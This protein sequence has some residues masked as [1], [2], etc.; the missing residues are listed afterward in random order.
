MN[1]ATFNN[2]E[3]YLYL[4]PSENPSTALISPVLDSTNYHSWSR[5]MITALSAKNKIEFVDGSAPEPLKTDRTYGAWRRCN[6]MVVSWIVHSVA[7]SIRQSILWMDKSED[8]WRDLKSRY[9]QGDLLRIF[10]LQQEASTLRQGA[11]SVTEYFTWLRVIWDEIENFRPDPVCTCNIRCSCSAF[12]IIAQRKLED[13]AMQF[14]RGLNEQYINIRSHVL[15]MDPIPAISKIFSYVVQQER[16]LLGNSSPNLNFEPKDVSINATKTICD[17]CG[18]IG[19]TKNVCYK[20]H[21]MPLNH[22]ARN[23]SMGG[24]KTCT[25]CGKIGHTIDVCYRK[26]GY[27][28][29]YKPYNGRPTVNNVTMMDSKPL[30]DQNQHHESQDLVRFSLEQYKALLTL[31]QQSSGGNTTLEQTK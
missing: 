2:I 19:H 17:H 18:R 11:L 1:E 12:A 8:I 29:G 6:N 21:G 3:S 13:R 4:H 9:S 27:P 16:Q 25:H 15:L 10:D 22:E 5:S 23:K 24:R 7:T 20:K 26:H 30:E 14:L 28:P 31:I